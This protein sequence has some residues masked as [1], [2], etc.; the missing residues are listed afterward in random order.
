MA[1][2]TQHEYLLRTNAEY[3]NRVVAET[4]LKMAQLVDALAV[5]NG[6]SFSHGKITGLTDEESAML[7]LLNLENEP[8][9]LRDQTPDHGVMTPASETI[10]DAYAMSPDPEGSWA[11]ET[12]GENVEEETESE[13]TEGETPRRRRRK[14]SEE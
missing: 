3:R 1:D 2:L 12:I 13:E 8:A 4:I 9:E 5:K 10:G 11:S 14:T 7:Q 6:L